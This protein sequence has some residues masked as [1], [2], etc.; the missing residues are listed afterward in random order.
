MFHRV[1]LDNE[2]TEFIEFKVNVVS[3]NL[4][5]QLKN[6]RQLVDRIDFGCTYY[7]SDIV[8]SF[9]LCNGSPV[10]LSYVAVLEEDGEGEEKVRISLFC[11]EK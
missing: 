4:Q 11:F 10:P 3:R 2:V 9:S 1:L 7:G 6:K 8:K 5:V